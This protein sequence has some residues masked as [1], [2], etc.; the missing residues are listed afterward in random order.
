MNDSERKITSRK[1]SNVEDFGEADRQPAIT[2]VVVL[3]L[4]LVAFAFEPLTQTKLQAYSQ[5]RLLLFGVSLV[6]RSG[7]QL[8]YVS[9]IRPSVKKG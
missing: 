8:P 6:H 7:L 1:V 4:V 2:G 3:V 5:L 9:L